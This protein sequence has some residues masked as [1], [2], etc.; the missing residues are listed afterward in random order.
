VIFLEAICPPKQAAFSAELQRSPTGNGKKN[1]VRVRLGKWCPPPGHHL[2][3]PVVW[4]KE[5]PFSIGDPSVASI[6]KLFQLVN[7]KL[8]LHAFK[9]LRY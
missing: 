3:L 5:G 1:V 9:D 2:N 4:I 6:F 8:R 7:A